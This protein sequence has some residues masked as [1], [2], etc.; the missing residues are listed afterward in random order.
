MIPLIF[1][2]GL[3]LSALTQHAWFDVLSSNSCACI[4][5]LQCEFGRRTMSKSID[6]QVLLGARALVEFRSTWTRY[7][8]ALTRGGRECDPTDPRAVRFCAHGALVRSAYDLTGDAR[9]ASRLAGSVAMSV[10]G[11]D[12]PQEAFE[13]IYT[14]N[15]GPAVSSRRAILHL[16]DRAL[17]RL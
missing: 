14:M 6:Y 10:T 15:D 16:F 7:H 13:D 2:L 17:G 1:Y 3:M 4:A 9:R 5:H 11:R 12:R 8:L